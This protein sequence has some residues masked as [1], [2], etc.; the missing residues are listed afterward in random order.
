[1]VHGR[2]DDLGRV[3]LFE[4]IQWRSSDARLRLNQPLPSDALIANPAH[5]FG[6]PLYRPAVDELGEG[7]DVFAFTLEKSDDGAT[8]LP[9]VECR[10]L[11]SELTFDLAWPELGRPNLRDEPAPQSRQVAADLRPHREDRPALRRC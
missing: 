4:P 2:L 1:M 8:L 9:R 5:N 3:P 7:E 10:P 11:S 6:H